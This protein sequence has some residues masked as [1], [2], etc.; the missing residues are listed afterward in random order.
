MTP[1]FG[2]SGRWIAS[3][4]TGTPSAIRARTSSTTKVSDSFGKLSTMTSVRGALARAGK[5]AGSPARPELRPGGVL[6]SR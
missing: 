2:R 5:S 6:L 1:R 3:T 4:L